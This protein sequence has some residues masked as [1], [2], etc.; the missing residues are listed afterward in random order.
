MT[1]VTAQRGQG[2]PRGHRRGH[3]GL[4]ERPCIEAD[5]DLSVPIELLREKGLAGVREARRPRPRTRVWSTLH[6]LQQHGGRRWSRSTAR[7]TSSPT[8]TSSRQLVKDVALHIAS[9]SAPR[10]LSRDD[11]PA[12]RDRSRERRSSR[13]RP[14]SR[15]SPTTSSPKIVEGKLNAF[16]K[17]LVLLDQP[18]VKDD[19]KTVQRA[20]GRG[21]G[22]AQ[23]EDRRPPVRPVQAR[24][25]RSSDE[26]GNG[27]RRPSRKVHAGGA[28]MTGEAVRPAHATSGSC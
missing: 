24:R 18:F 23:G 3:D 17:D 25:G 13:C 19:S 14:R 4:Q 7:R 5:G 12:G 26:P 6:P 9:P 28:Q 11:V 27:A 21:R 1:E 16:F 20:A 15:A 22:P 2:A 8:P 10:Y